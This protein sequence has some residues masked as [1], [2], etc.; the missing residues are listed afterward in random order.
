[1]T[2]PAKKSPGKYVAHV[3][4]PRAQTMEEFIME[5]SKDKTFNVSKLQEL[6]ALR[7]VMRDEA[8][9]E[10]FAK[11]Y[12]NLCD[13]LPRVIATKVNTERP[14]VKYAPLADINDTI[15]PVM[16]VHNMG[17]MFRVH[18]HE[19]QITVTA[20]CWH[21]NGHR[22][23]CPITMPIDMTGPK[24]TTIRTKAEGIASAVTRAKTVAIR[25][26]LNISTGEEIPEGRPEEKVKD[27]FTEAMH[28]EGADR[29][30]W[31]GK[32]IKVGASSVRGKWATPIEA[33]QELLRQ[34]SK[35]ELKLSRI[36]TINGNLGL[37]AALIENNQGN[38][39]GEMHKIADE[40]K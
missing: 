36:D 34:L 2:K 35:L 33:G 19:D 37:I 40:G 1:M 22:E 11:D 28:Q 31:D 30:K 24:G 13:E 9:Q 26:L 4:E 21:A 17:V 18:Q 15:R 16:K 23:E 38:L 12:V 5:A 10:A 32:T 20:I 3:Q 14:T 25:A 6:V 39:V 27:E 8:K 29:E 7:K